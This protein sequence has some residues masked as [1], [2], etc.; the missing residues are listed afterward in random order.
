MDTNNRL[1]VLLITY[2]QN[3]TCPQHKQNNNVKC[4]EQWCLQHGSD[5]CL[6]AATI[7]PSLGILLYMSSAVNNNALVNQLDHIVSTSPI[8]DHPQISRQIICLIFQQIISSFYQPVT[9]TH[10]QTLRT[11]GIHMQLLTQYFLF[12][13]LMKLTQLLS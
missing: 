2:I 10:N 9:T 12:C 8:R 13:K 5:Q 11:V 3:N 6:R 1:S 7:L 4:E